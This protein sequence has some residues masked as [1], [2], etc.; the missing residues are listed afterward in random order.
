MQGSL[1]RWIANAWTQTGDLGVSSHSFLGQGAC[2]ACLYLPTQKSKNEDQIIAEGL[3]VPQ[4][5]TH[6]R[7]L[8]GTGRGV[9][10]KICDEIASAFGL[11]S[12]M[13]AP[14]IGRPIR[15]LWVEGV[16]GGGFIPLG[17]VEDTPREV[18]VPLAFQSALAGMLLAAEAVRDV[19]NPDDQTETYIRQMDVL[20]Q[21][22]ST[23]RQ[24]RRKVGSGAC[25]CEDQDFIDAYRSKYCG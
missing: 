15:D 17:G 22:G 6:I 18:Q 14:Y 5:Q 3:R 24:M 13:L 9:D 8:L 11:A 25:I 1:P 7:Q 20:S 10:K 2:L 19:L 21:L 12:G 16:C 23:N 4:L